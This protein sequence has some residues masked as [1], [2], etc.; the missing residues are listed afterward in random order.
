MKGRPILFSASMVRAILEGHKTQTRRVVKHPFRTQLYLGRSDDYGNGGFHFANAPLDKR[1]H[2]DFESV[3]LNCPYGR[4]GERLW[5]RETCSAEE[6]TAE[7]EKD[8]SLD[9]LDGV[10]YA[11]DGHFEPI[12]DT[13]A[14]ADAWGALNAYRGKHGAVV[15]A[16][17][18]PRWASRIT[19][20]IT[21]VRVQRVQDIDESDAIA[22]GCDPSPFVRGDDDLMVPQMQQML[23]FD[24]PYPIA[25]FV[26]L[27]DSING[28][29]AGVTNWNANPWVW[30]LTLK[31]VE[32]PA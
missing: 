32:Q 11:A 20:E 14:A 4:L 13:P 7:T 23:G 31:R 27:W 12:K 9:G 1:T 28:K 30:A 22:E 17:H 3:V 8:R 16:I 10:R 21:D 2:R 26:L 19:L 18:M 29:Q 25:R 5:V 6:L 24:S 15:P